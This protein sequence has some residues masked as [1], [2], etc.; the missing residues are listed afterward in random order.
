MDNLEKELT[1]CDIPLKPGEFLA[2]RFGAA[3]LAG[4]VT[5][6]LSHNP[7]IALAVLGLRRPGPAHSGA[8]DQALHAYR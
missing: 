1:Q 7:I 5:I 2:V 3:I 8:Q 6:L 4:L